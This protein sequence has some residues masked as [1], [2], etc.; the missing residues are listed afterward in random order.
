MESTYDPAGLNNM[1]VGPVG[2]FYLFKYLT[3]N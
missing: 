1:T 3:T 2:S